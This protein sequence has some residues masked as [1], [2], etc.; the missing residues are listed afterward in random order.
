MWLTFLM[1]TEN[2]ARSSAFQ[3][4]GIAVEEKLRAQRFPFALL[5][6]HDHAGEVGQREHRHMV[7]RAEA[8]KTFL[9]PFRAR[10]GLGGHGAFDRLCG[11]E[12]LRRGL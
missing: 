1:S 11:A 7:R 6:L 2:S 4:P 8:C 9:R 12:R 5:P 10:H 3:S